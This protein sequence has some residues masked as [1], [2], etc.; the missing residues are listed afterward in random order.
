[1]KINCIIVDDESLA[2]KGLKKYVEAIDFLDLKGL[3][4]NAMQANTLLKT[5]T[6]DLVFLDIEMPLI[7]GMDFLK[8]L[9]NPPKVIFTTAYSEYAL[10]SF[11]FD[12]IDYLVKPISFERFLQACN[13]AYKVFETPKLEIPVTSKEKKEEQD[14]LF[15]K[16]DHELV[17]INHD[18][19]LFIEGMQN[20]I[21]I[22]TLTTNHVVLVPLKNVFTLLPDNRFYQVHKSYVIPLDKVQAISGN[23]IIISQHKIPV[24]RNKKNEVLDILTRNKI[25]KK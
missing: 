13:K 14:Y 21:R 24:S 15:V 20:Y 19:I 18:D 23:Q 6:I 22:Y 4:I 25:L 2:R 12:V 5:E 3:C 8:S 7:S 10:E 16:V 9:S 1:M 11:A 17:K